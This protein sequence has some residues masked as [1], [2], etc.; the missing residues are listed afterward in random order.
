ME[1][2]VDRIDVLDQGFGFGRKLLALTDH[3]VTEHYSLPQLLQLLCDL[4][5]WADGFELCVLAE[6]SPNRILLV[7][8]E[9][10]VFVLGDRVRND[11][12]ARGQLTVQN[13]DFVD[14]LDNFGDN[15][16]CQQ[17]T[18]NLL[19]RNQEVI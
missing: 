2:I 11:F 13:F 3:C 4:F 9:D 10:I 14:V 7:D 16:I 19:Y 5:C 1:K 17:L 8:G 6:L 15:R 18:V 12:D